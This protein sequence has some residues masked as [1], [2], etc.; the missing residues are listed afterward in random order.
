MT[1]EYKQSLTELNRIIH[2]MD[3]DYLK[4]LPQKFIEFV[5]SNMDKEYTPNIDKNIPLNE[6]NLKDDTKVLLSLLYRNYWCDSKKKK[7]L[8]QEDLIE[9]NNLEKKLR[10]K[11]NPDNVFKNNSNKTKTYIE[12]KKDE[13]HTELI[14]YKEKKWY[15]KIFAKIL[16]FFKNEVK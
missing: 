11:Y 13:Q 9:K 8:L 12:P 7:T 4:K 15:Q 1:I 6:Q 5:N 2:Y 3:E 10:E 16:S 14:K